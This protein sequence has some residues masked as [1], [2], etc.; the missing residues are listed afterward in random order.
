[1]ILKLR[2]AK[3]NIA[4]WLFLRQGNELPDARQSVN[5]GS[6]NQ[7]MGK[8]EKRLGW[9]FWHPLCH[10]NQKAIFMYIYTP[11]SVPSST[12]LQEVNQHHGPQLLPTVQLHAIKSPGNQPGY[13]LHA[14][15]VSRTL[16]CI[17]S[18]GPV[19]RL[20]NAVQ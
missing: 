2:Q 3:M 6:E 5:S 7:Q 15:R 16:Q 10:Y 8:K 17:T 19:V 12:S 18:P 14:G 20:V 11:A 1:M 4:W 13:F 9:S